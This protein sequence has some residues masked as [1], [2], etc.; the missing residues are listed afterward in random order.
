MKVLSVQNPYAFLLLCGAKRWETRS[1]PTS[2]R[3]PLA[4]ASS[5]SINAEARAA[6]R[7]PSV[8]AELAAAGIDPDRAIKLLPL[9][10]ILGVVEVVDSLSIDEM[11]QAA[12]G[13]V[14]AC[15][16][17]WRGVEPGRNEWFFGD[18]GQGRYA[19]LT[20]NPRRLTTP[21]DAR[22]CMREIGHTTPSSP[23]GPG[24]TEI[25]P[26]GTIGALGEICAGCRGVLTEATA[27]RAGRLGMWDYPDAEIRALLPAAPAGTS[28]RDPSGS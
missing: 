7:Q 14:N 12:D 5:A 11:A 13:T 3:G 27:R 15:R 1:R 18:Y 8:R 25:D 28:S 22:L 23:T 2:H 6:F 10:V 20:R 26:C 21:I 19:Y 24:E 9:G 17:P 16:Q 4:I